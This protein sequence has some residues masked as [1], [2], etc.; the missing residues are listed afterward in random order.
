MGRETAGPRQT[1][2]T[3]DELGGKRKIIAVFLLISLITIS[4]LHFVGY[5]HIFIS[6]EIRTGTRTLEDDEFREFS[7]ED[8]QDRDEDGNEDDEFRKISDEDGQ[9]KDGNEDDQFRELLDED[10]QDKEKVVTSKDEDSENIDVLQTP[11]ISQ[12]LE[13]KPPSIDETFKQR[14]SIYRRSCSLIDKLIT[15][16]KEGLTN[17]SNLKCPHN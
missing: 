2:R 12:R 6:S 17:E 14:E 5:F 15:M 9:D 7:D 3:L 11:D 10:G 16:N 1:G 4:Y 8:G 13:T